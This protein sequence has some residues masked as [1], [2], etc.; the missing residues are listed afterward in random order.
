MNRQPLRSSNLVSV[1][2]EPDSEDSARGVL[3]VEFRKGIVYR[4]E[5]VPETLYR[6][7]LFAP[8]AGKFFHEQIASQYAGE[9]A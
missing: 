2:F 3:E 4:Y 8:S 7:L 9:L 1:G 6:E 5:D